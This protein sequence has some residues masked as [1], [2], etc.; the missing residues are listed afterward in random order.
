MMSGS[1]SEKTGKKV[2]LWWR[3]GRVGKC[4]L[5]GEKGHNLLGMN[6]TKQGNPHSYIPRLRRFF[7]PNKPSDLSKNNL[8]SLFVLCLQYLLFLYTIPSEPGHLQT[9]VC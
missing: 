4:M 1:E 2:N 6:C 7:L 9:S 8:N 3:W 5:S